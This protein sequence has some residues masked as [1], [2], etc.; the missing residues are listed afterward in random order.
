M[1]AAASEAPQ[2]SPREEEQEAPQE[3]LREEGHKEEGQEKVSVQKPVLQP[4]KEKNGQHKPKD[5][6]LIMDVPL[7]FSVLLGESNTSIR[8]ILSLGTGSVVE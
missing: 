8:D 6:D 5:F 3:V 4:L 1:E 2:A 7:A